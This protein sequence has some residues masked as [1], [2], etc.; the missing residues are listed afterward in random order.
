[1]RI[2]N[3]LS[4]ED[5]VSEVVDFVTLLGILVLSIGMIGV[6]G[7]PL[8]KSAQEGN[9]IENTKQSFIVMGENLNKVVLGQAPSQNVEFKMYGEM[10]SVISAS[11]RTS[12]ININLTVYNGTSTSNISYISYEYDLGVIEAEFDTAIVG[13]ENSGTWVNYSSGG[14]IM[15]S[16]PVFVI[17]NDSMYIPVTTISGSAS[18]GGTGLVHMVAK[19][20]SSDFVHTPNV[21]SVKILVNSSYAQGWQQR[22]LKE[23]TIFYP[24]ELFMVRAF[25]PPVNVYIQRKVINVQIQ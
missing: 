18:I 2:I 11:S 12:S 6:A 14:T 20:I 1:M 22:F 19:E 21:S 4:S 24:S 16:K 3:L 5:A 15:L 9:H 13:Y 10:L 17:S 23:T 25:N 8:L 7:Y